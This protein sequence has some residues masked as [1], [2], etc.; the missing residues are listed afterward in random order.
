MDHNLGKVSSFIAIPRWTTIWEKLVLLLQ[1]LL[2]DM[3]HNLGK[4]SS[5]IATPRWTTI[6][7][8]L[9]LLLL[10]LDGPQSGKS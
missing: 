6:W 8:K 2:L 3:D 1:S 10:F 7:E 9:V 4:V 5:F